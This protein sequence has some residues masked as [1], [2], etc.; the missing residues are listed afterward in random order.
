M[1]ASRSWGRAPAQAAIY[2][3]L[4]SQQSSRGLVYFSHLPETR[5]LAP[6]H[7]KRTELKDDL[8]LYLYLPEEDTDQCS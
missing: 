4:L 7:T 1:R 2:G 6:G 8:T 3:V 5:S